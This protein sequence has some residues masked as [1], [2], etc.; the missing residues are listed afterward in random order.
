MWN[1]TMFVDLD[2][3]LNAS[4]LLS[5]SAELLVLIGYT[6]F[7]HV[8][9]IVPCA[10][11]TLVVRR[12][13]I[14]LLFVDVRSMSDNILWDKLGIW[15]Y[16]VT[17]GFSDREAWQIRRVR[18]DSLFTLWILVSGSSTQWLKWFCE[19]GLTWRSQ[20]GANPIPIPTPLIWRYLGIK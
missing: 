6:Y 4:S 20:V 11:K 8:I 3:P 1:G 2:W 18:S 13:F 17:V 15:V 5:A 9:R 16:Y 14:Y 7:Y 12:M 10:R 19:A